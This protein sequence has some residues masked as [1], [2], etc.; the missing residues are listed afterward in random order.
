MGDAKGA[1]ST[2]ERDKWG[3]GEPGKV[4]Q[5]CPGGCKK[6][7]RI[8][9]SVGVAR[10][11]N[12]PDQY[13]IGA[14]TESFKTPDRFYTLEADPKKPSK[15]TLVTDAVNNP[16][17]TTYKDHKTR[18]AAP[19]VAA[20]PGHIRRQGARFR[21]YEYREL[22]DGTWG[23][24]R[25]ITSDEAEIEWTV[26]VANKKAV[27]HQFDGPKLGATRQG[28]TI[29]PPESKL[30][31]KQG[32]DETKDPH[33]RKALRDPGKVVD[34]LGEILHDEKGR[35]IFLGGRGV[36]KVDPA[37]PGHVTSL[38]DYSN[39]VGWVDD[40]C[41]GWISAKL[42]F[43]PAGGKP[44][45][46]FETK[47]THGD[48]WV[49][50]GPPDYGPELTNVTSIYDTMLDVAVR[51]M[52]PKDETD[53]VIFRMHGVEDRAKATYFPYFDYDLLRLFEAT[54]QT[55]TVFKPANPPMKHP[56]VYK[57]ARDTHLDDTSDPK[58]AFLR[59]KIFNTLRPPKEKLRRDPHPLKK[60][61]PAP[62]PPDAVERADSQSGD[63]SGDPDYIAPP[64]GA[65]PND[66]YRYDWYRWT[67]PMLWSDSNTQADSYRNTR[68]AITETQYKAV[69]RWNEGNFVDTKGDKFD[70]IRPSEEITPGGLDRAALDRG[71]G[72]PFFPGIEASWLVRSPDVY[73]EPLRPKKNEK[74]K[75]FTVGPFKT[76]GVSASGKTT[77][78]AGFFSQQMAQPWQADFLACT[79]D[80]DPTPPAPGASPAD[81]QTYR[82]KLLTARIGW[83]PAQ[84]PD[85]VVRGDPARADPT[86]L[87]DATAVTST[88]RKVT[89]LKA[90]GTAELGKHAR[91]ITV[92]SA[93]KRPERAPLKAKV[94]GKD[95]AGNVLEE[96]VPLKRVAGTA[97]GNLLFAFV[98][99]V[100]F[101]PANLP[102]AVDATI[103]IGFDGDAAS[104]SGLLDAQP[105]KVAP[106]TIPSSGLK[107]SGLA[108]LATKPRHVTF[109]VG[110]VDRD[111]A[112]LTATVKGTDGDGNPT[113]ST[114][115]LDSTALA[116]T[117]SRFTSV[118]EVAFSAAR[119]KLDVTVSIGIGEFVGN[120]ERWDKGVSSYDENVE[121]WFRLGFVVKGVEIE[122][123][124][125]L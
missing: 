40:V 76:T 122:R 85:D 57:L 110:G 89:K 33:D 27:F 5:T 71:V 58:S 30:K 125:T 31:I 66:L 7:Y 6:M 93:G 48:A 98:S 32:F 92:T 19:G 109:T 63:V 67:M 102:D 21:I 41:D 23:W 96:S 86:A 36:S 65:D 24:T 80:P 25:E 28:P 17:K 18:P 90:T 52:K 119:P 104:P 15:E 81:L 59:Y 9:P 68:F 1:E 53:R 35:L 26:K 45:E 3:K 4:K 75:D 101:D 82:E 121:R 100:A 113:T 88:G 106:Q 8:H 13:F 112:P 29:E 2:I 84:R 79:R 34:Y 55:A 51:T 22:K 43:P 83:W 87:E 39:N 62:N 11:G 124:P 95:E 50:V 78:G 60:P 16:D 56:A 69:K 72:G 74:A 108:A 114:V 54:F 99:E 103:S 105:G 77:V 14:E 120:M 64:A 111:E 116:A 73:L 94:K 42:K 47:N 115:T 97:S 46:T 91:N 117:P 10:V 12:A 44:A 107:P 20:D 49:F 61:A 70:D 123:D 38:D 118:T 37:I